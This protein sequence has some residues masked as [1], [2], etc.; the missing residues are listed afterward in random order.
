MDLWSSGGARTFTLALPANSNAQMPLLL[1]LHGGAQYAS[2]FLDMTA[3]DTAGPASGYVV[4]APDGRPGSGGAGGTWAL[5]NDPGDGAGD[6]YSDVDDKVFIRDV[7]S[8]I[9]SLGVSLSGDLYVTGWSLGAK[10][11]TRLACAAAVNNATVPP[12]RV[13]ALTIASGIQA[14]TER[15]CTGAPVPLLMIQARTPRAEFCKRPASADSS[16]SRWLFSFVRR[17]AQIKTFRCAPLRPSESTPTSP[18]PH[19]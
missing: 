14:E 1:A 3:F 15:A 16:G 5:N 17:A 6:V 19:I 9:R 2:G 10:F 11:A 13:V 7:V 8:C 4:A 18:P 12:L